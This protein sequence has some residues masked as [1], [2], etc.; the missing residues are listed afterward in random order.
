MKNGYAELIARILGYPAT[1]IVSLTKEDISDIDEA[2]KTLLNESMAKV[3][4]L[5]Y[6][7][8]KTFRKSQQELHISHTRVEQIE[9]DALY[10][11]RD[12][13]VEFFE[14]FHPRGL[15]KLVNRLLIKVSEL[16]K[17]VAISRRIISQSRGIDYTQIPH[18]LLGKSVLELELPTRARNCLRDIGIR[19]I[20]DLISMSEYALLRHKNFG[21]KSLAAIKEELQ[22]YGLSLLH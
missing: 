20:Q 12:K 4:R 14:L 11:L 22:D 13:K 16:E 3:L 19:T 6:F 17:E 18:Y 8:E 7:E 5:R 21:L 2:L 1:E 9:K 15:R 10:L